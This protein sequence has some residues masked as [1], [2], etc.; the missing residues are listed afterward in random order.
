MLPVTT[1]TI[2][3]EKKFNIELTKNVFLLTFLKIITFK[4]FL[5]KL[6]LKYYYFEKIQISIKKS[7][8]TDIR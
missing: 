7:L 4:Y 1:Y 3:T 5:T 6:R 8:Y 2:K